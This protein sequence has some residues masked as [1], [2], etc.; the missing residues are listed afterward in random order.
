MEVVKVEEVVEEV[1]VEEV[2]EAEDDF[3]DLLAQVQKGL[4]EHDAGQAG[5]L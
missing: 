5:E 2:V 3:D 4:D 1:K